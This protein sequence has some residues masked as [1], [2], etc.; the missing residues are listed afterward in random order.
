MKRTILMLLLG[1]SSFCLFGQKG[2]YANDTLKSVGVTIIDGGDIRNSQICRVNYGDKIVDYPPSQISEYGFDD[3]FYFA[4]D[5]VI[6]GSIKRVF[7]ERVVDGYKSLYYYRARGITLFFVDSGDND[8]LKLP[9]VDEV[10]GK[11]FRDVLVELTQDCEH[12]VDF[13]GLVSYSKR[14]M[15]EL[16]NRYNQCRPSTFTRSKMGVTISYGFSKLSPQKKFVGNE[17]LNLFG[18]DYQGGVSFGLFY[19]MPL[20]FQNFNIHLG[21]NVSQS[22]QSLRE[23]GTFEWNSSINNPPNVDN[24]TYYLK[25]ESQFIEFPIMARY[26]LFTGKRFSPF[27]NAGGHLSYS[28]SNEAII[29]QALKEENTITIDLFPYSTPA[30]YLYAGYNIGLGLEV[31]LNPRSSIFFETRVNQMFPLGISR[32]EIQFSNT[33]FNLF[34]GFKF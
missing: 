11:K 4:K 31:M 21:I 28:F 9:K 10:S 24:I 19:E 15:T 33:S 7:L 20:F 34:T 32:A 14:S 23:D 29:Y 12:T 13:V 8:L 2:F 26:Y 1:L 3:R 22:A 5:I 17:V 18:Y 27:I 25:R 6:D 30:S 16:F